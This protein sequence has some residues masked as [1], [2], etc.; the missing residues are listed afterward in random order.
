PDDDAPDV[1]LAVPPL[2]DE[3][4]G[5]PPARREQRRHVGAL[6]LQQHRAVAR[7]AELRD[8]RQVDRKSTRLNSSHVQTSYAVFCLKKKKR[9]PC[10][11]DALT[12]EPSREAIRRPTA[13]TSPRALHGENA[14]AHTPTSP[15]A[16]ATVA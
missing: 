16:S 14:A 6:Q 15:P 9:D 7:A 13:R 5:R 11:S 3:R 4:L 2:G 1:R 8:R 10:P 12:G